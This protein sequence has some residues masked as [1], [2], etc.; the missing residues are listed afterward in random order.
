MTA[1]SREAAV[2][3]PARQL[4]TDAW[5]A[6]STEALSEHLVRFD[7][8]FERFL[9]ARDFTLLEISP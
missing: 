6:A 3:A 5:I 2:I 4:I 8:D 9:P 7:R 1:G